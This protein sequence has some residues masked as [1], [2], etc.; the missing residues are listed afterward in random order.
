MVS[1]PGSE[2]LLRLVCELCGCVIGVA[3]AVGGVPGC[4]CVAVVC[5]TSCSC[6]LD[7]RRVDGVQCVRC[8]RACPLVGCTMLSLSFCLPWSSFGPSICVKVVAVSVAGVPGCVVGCDASSRS[9][10]VYG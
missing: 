5:V 3:V 7:L 2:M 10:R 9:R 1:V 4:V 6:V 8:I